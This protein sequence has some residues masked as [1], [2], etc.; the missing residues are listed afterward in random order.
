MKNIKDYQKLSEDS[1]QTKEFVFKAIKKLN[2]NLNNWNRLFWTDD[3]S[4]SNAFID[5]V[6]DEWTVVI[7]WIHNKWDLIRFLDDYIYDEY[8][9]LFDNW[10]ELD[11][12][13]LINDDIAR[14]L[15][16]ELEE[17]LFEKTKSDIASK[18]IEELVKLRD[19]VN[20]NY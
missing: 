19:Y 12:E 16:D 17:Q 13:N 3:I 1:K 10:I 18:Y 7:S 5:F 9:L 14:L 15:W 8:S 11:S 20:D 2:L 4:F 6:N